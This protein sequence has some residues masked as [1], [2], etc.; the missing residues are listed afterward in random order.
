[1]NPVALA[2][3]FYEPLGLLVKLYALLTK[4]QRAPHPGS[5][6]HDDYGG[7]EKG[8][9]LYAVGALEY[10]RHQRVEEDEGDKPEGKGRP[11]GV[12]VPEGREHHGE[13]GRGH[14]HKYAGG[15][16]ASLRVHVGV[17]DNCNRQSYGGV[18]QDQWPY[19][20]TPL[21]RHAIAGQVPG[22][23]VQEPGQRRSTGEGQDHDGGEIINGAKDAAQVLVR[24]VGESPPVGG[25]TRL[26]LLR[27]Y[28][29]HCDEACREQVE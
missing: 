5:E 10:V 4:L 8:G 7:D 16:G 27:G 9:D 28:E 12:V 6:R 24:Q 15:V 22:D 18:D 14:D 25:T 26:E 3:F 29:N 17:E 21:G 19:R 23:H 11:Q 20:P 13:G 1:M 2:G